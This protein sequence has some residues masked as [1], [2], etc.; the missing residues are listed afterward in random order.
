MFAGLPD[1]PGGHDRIPIR[2]ALVSAVLLLVQSHLRLQQ[3]H[4]RAQ[5]IH[6]VHLQTHKL[7]QVFCITTA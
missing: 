5:T 1:P 2:T 4:L 3:L 6:S 7:F